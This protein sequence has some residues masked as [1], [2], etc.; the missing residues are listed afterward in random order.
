MLTKLAGAALLFVLL[1]QAAFAAGGIGGA[2]MGV[3]WALPFAGMLLSIALGPVLFPH[4]WELNYGKF[5]AF[6]AVLVVVP[7]VL[8]RGVDP[9]LGRRIDAA[10]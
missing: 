9:A 10:E 5:A 3:A 1:P 2:T 8:F 6:W 7:L 4:F